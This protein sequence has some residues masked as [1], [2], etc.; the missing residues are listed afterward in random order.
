MTNQLTFHFIF[1]LS[2][3]FSSRQGRS[4]F[5]QA[6]ENAGAVFKKGITKDVTHLLVPDK[7]DPPYSSSKV[8]KTVSEATAAGKPIMDEQ[9]ILNQLE[10]TS[11]S[12][13]SSGT[14]S[15]GGSMQKTTSSS[16]SSSSTSNKVS[17]ITN[18]VSRLFS[19][20]AHCWLSLVSF[21]DIFNLAILNNNCKLLLYEL[22]EVFASLNLNNVT[23][24]FD[25]G[26][27]SRCIQHA[28][29][30]LHVF[31]VSNA[32]H[33]FTAQSLWNLNTPHLRCLSLTN[34]SGITGTGLVAALS[35]G[36]HPKLHTLELVGC[37]ETDWFT[38]LSGF[39]EA[40][41]PEKNTH[42]NITRLLQKY[43]TNEHVL[44][45]RLAKKYNVKLQPPTKDAFRSKHLEDLQQQA[46]LTLCCDIFECSSCGNI[47]MKDCTNRQCT[48]K[49]CCLSTKPI[50]KSCTPQTQKCCQGCGLCRCAQC[51]EQNE[52]DCVSVMTCSYCNKNL[53]SDCFNLSRYHSPSSIPMTFIKRPTCL[54]NQC[55]F[56]ET[57]VCKKKRNCL[58]RYKKNHCAGSFSKQCS[59]CDDEQCRRCVRNCGQ[60]DTFLCTKCVHIKCS[61]CNKIR[62]NECKDLPEKCTT[63]C[64]S[65]SKRL[66]EK[67]RDR[68]RTVTTCS[69]CKLEGICVECIERCGKCDTF[70][71]TTCIHVKCESCKEIR[72]NECKD[73]PEKCTTQCV[74][75]SKRLCEK[76]GDRSRTVTTCSS[77]KLEGI[78]VDCIEK[79]GECDS[80]LC[81]ACI[82]KHNVKCESCEE[83]RCDACG[84][85][86]KLCTTQQCPE[87]EEM[88]CT[89]GAKGP[90][91][92]CVGCGAQD[93]CIDCSAY[94]KCSTCDEVYVCERKSCQEGGHFF[95][96]AACDE[97][98]CTANNPGECN[99]CGVRFCVNCATD[100]T[101]DGTIHNAHGDTCARNQWQCCG[102]H[103][104]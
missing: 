10:L 91:P 97:V 88:E 66:C 44:Y 77:C 95:T 104:C 90:M 7:N 46:N 60:C 12:G 96:C 68:S 25:D 45:E 13:L 100:A 18:N 19:N 5:E 28:G 80:L 37:A 54:A 94:T 41:A 61:S 15:N 32:S 20:T 79:C 39:Y 40:V 75:C 49:Y 102:T 65:C 50:C 84:G 70:L 31:R 98:V 67:I 2:F 17:K 76:I 42:A 29:Q 33:T 81:V 30:M 3:L 34:C 92:K 58:C 82:D 101:C 35:S 47:D 51:N 38:L 93:S 85:L 53:C 83:I 89:W 69:S 21:C 57:I 73:L 56:C 62:C 63:Q 78:C 24:H 1:L 36:H 27:A 9:W 87:C 71:C 4:Q 23:S 86:P 55:L 64:V 8:S 43:K 103:I 16:S 6:C 22:P 26:A 72:C 11:W 14:S 74:S 52:N 48:S 59:Q 99:D